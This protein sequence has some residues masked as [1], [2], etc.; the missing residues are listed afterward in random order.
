MITYV[1]G[2]DIGNA[3]TE[4]ALGKIQDG[5]LLR[6]TSGITKTTGIKGTK[7]NLYGMINSLKEACADMD[8]PLSSLDLIRINEA[9]PVIGD[10]AMETITQT[11]ITESAMIGHNPDTPGG[12]GLGIGYTVFLEDLPAADK[13]KPHIVIISEEHDFITAAREVNLA[14]EDGYSIKGLIVQNDDGV[15]ICNRLSET[16][17]IVDEVSL[18][19][20]VPVDYLCAVE[21][22]RPGASIDFLTN[23]YGIA[24]AFS[25]SSAETKH[26]IHIAKALIGNRSAVVI[27]TPSGSIHERIIPAGEIIIDGQ[28]QQYR[29]N[30][31][32]GAQ[33]IMDQVKRAGS[34][35][36][37]HGSSGTNV[38]GMLESVRKKMAQV[39]DTPEDSIFIQDLM[40][41]DTLVPQNVIGSLANEFYM[42][43]SVGIAA[44]VKTQKLHM[45]HLAALLEETVGCPTEIGGVEGDMAVLGTLTTPGS[46]TPILV[47]DIGAGSTDSCY[48]HSDGQKKTIHLA[49]AGNMVTELIQAEL[50]LSSREEA[51]AIKKYPLARAESLFHL[52][53]EDGSVEFFKEPLHSDFFAKLLSIQ[54]DGYLP[55]NTR[56]SLE[57]VRSVRREIKRKV[58]VNNV[59]RALLK[60]SA[61]GTLHE[62]EHVVLVGG[63]SLDFELPNMLTD[64]LAYYGIT[65]GKGNI[66]GCMG[67][68]NAV[69]SGLLYAFLQKEE[70]FDRKS[71]PQPDGA[72]KAQKGGGHE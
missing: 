10:F 15:L 36:D 59:L 71:S 20:K 46:G 17:P 72:A 63:S 21:V 45:Q 34:I 51:E 26:V 9:T 54:P 53:H 67:P 2:I 41:V 19:D 18:I 27:K 66:R 33:K 60:V 69:A 57:K 70:A 52:R 39:T 68:R 24:T 62:F 13:Q 14:I 56:H 11:V 43:K 1:A 47:V 55:I 6:C 44:M 48:L 37:V 35:R 30:V 12:L 58:L 29:V 16:L 64:V 42:E 31:D 7:D 4:T 3:T 40:A 28:R 5:R 22:A 49:G 65:S 23:P 50:G 8:I 61:T 32:D 25:L 38:G